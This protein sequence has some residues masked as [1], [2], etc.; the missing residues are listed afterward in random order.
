MSIALPRWDEHQLRLGREAGAP[1]A[2]R[3]VVD[4][5][6][7]ALTNSTHDEFFGLYSNNSSRGRRTSG[8]APLPPPPHQPQLTF[9]GAPPYDDANTVARRRRC[10]GAA[11]TAPPEVT[12]ISAAMVAT[13][14]PKRGSNA[15][16]GPGESI[17]FQTVMPNAAS[18]P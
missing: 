8:N 4:F 10:N 9:A 2:A 16:F 11:A 15:A 1:A 18:A 3:S 13:N 17:S 12:A 6:S 5:V 14:A 7:P